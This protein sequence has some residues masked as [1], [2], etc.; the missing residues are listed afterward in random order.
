MNTP[1]DT[2][3][4]G[5]LAAALSLAAQGIAVFPAGHDKRPLLKGWQSKAT[6]DLTQIESWWR[7]YPNAMPAL[8]TGKR[9]G[10]V[11]LDVDRKNGKDGF[12]ELAALG[13]DIEALS[14]TQVA[15]PGDGRH[16][17]FS[18][19]EG[20]S[21]RSTGLP[22][23]LDVRGEGGLV[24]APGAVNGRGVYE[25]LSGSLTDNL[26]RWPNALP[27]RRKAVEPVEA[28]PTGLSWPV[29]AEAV[30]AVP[31]DIRDRETW[32]A[33]LASIHAESG[34]SEVG[35][36]LAHEWSERHSTNDPTETDRVWASF[37]R[38]DGA[39][40]W[41]FISEAERRGWSHPAVAD[42]RRAIAVAGLD[43]AWDADELAEI[44]RRSSKATKAAWMASMRRAL[45]AEGLDL[46]G[47]S[48]SR[49]RFLSPTDCEGL[50]ARSYVLKGLLGEGDIAAIVGAPGAGKSLLAPF[51]GFAVAQGV[52]AFGRRTRQGGV[53]YVA[54]EDS[55]GMRA[56]VQALRGQRG[57]AE[58]FKLVEGVSDLLSE[59]SEDLRL[60]L[61]ATE[62]QRPALI[63]IDT[64]AV[65]F[66]GLEENDAKSMGR[67]VAVA[68]RLA[69]WGAAVV[70][71]HHDTKEGSGLP[72]GHSI[73][74]GALDMSLHLKRD[75]KVV[76]VRPTKNRNGST[77][78][79]LAFSVGTIQMGTD[80]DGDAI[81]TATCDEENAAH[82]PKREKPLP[83]SAKAALDILEGLSPEG[84]FILK[85]EWRA[86]C[87][88]SDAV[89]GADRIDDRRQAFRRALEQLA[90]RK[91]FISRGEEIRLAESPDFLLGGDDDD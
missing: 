51:L 27:I 38:S 55:H 39:T 43:D 28:R 52:E 47:L 24:V 15:T 44:D 63:V 6:S 82:L 20:M 11:V 23:G 64:L 78:Q 1:N 53:F 68:R 56:R 25:L 57:D 91:L 40:G 83:P 30:R 87:L 18:W 31:N 3:T 71:I 62:D 50:P 14:D 59:G 67:V 7:E 61:V 77:D 4:Q 58:A 16:I 46:L 88:K 85:S 26:P 10:I 36:E 89:S 42:L 45:D 17:Y 84:Q 74:N 37:K 9:N 12:T 66:P 79:E 41:R 73:L 34:G 69:R 75:G 13:L 60:L 35:L 86:G 8:P 22:P 29:F 90:R 5:N 65:A 49:L 21:N 48:P 2:A 19:S 32:V 81:W 54:A 33:R 80:E 72:R 76:R 70:L